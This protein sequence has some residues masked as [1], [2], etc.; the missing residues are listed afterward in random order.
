MDSRDRAFVAGLVGCALF[1]VAFVA[2]LSASRA[3]VEA[4]GCM[5][6]S[7]CEALYGVDVALPV[8]G[9]V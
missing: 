3:P 5:T 2:L 1:V 8:A 6:D 4:G 7:E 9:E